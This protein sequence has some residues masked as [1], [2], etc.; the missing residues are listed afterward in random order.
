M[1]SGAVTRSLNKQHGPARLC[2]S[3]I[4]LV[5]NEEYDLRYH[6]GLKPDID[7]AENKPFVNNC[8]SWIIKKVST[9]IS[10]YSIITEQSKG[11]TS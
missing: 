11:G 1:A 7:E 6:K 9:V 10:S 4:G 3:S 8:I 5:S 2:R